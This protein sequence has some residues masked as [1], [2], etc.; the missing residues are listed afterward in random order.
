MEGV[1][2]SVHIGVKQSEPGLLRLRI[3][4]P[5]LHAS[6]HRPLQRP[7]RTMRNFRFQSFLLSVVVFKSARV[8]V[9][10]FGRESTHLTMGMRILGF[11]RPAGGSQ[12]QFSLRGSRILYRV[13]CSKMAAST[14]RVQ[15]VFILLR[16]SYAA[17]AA[18]QQQKPASPS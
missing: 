10:M 6:K 1:P 13:R 9:T 3:S 7:Y 4:E 15:I 14:V 17:A 18:M 2:F 11:L 5:G 12:S 16:S 8:S